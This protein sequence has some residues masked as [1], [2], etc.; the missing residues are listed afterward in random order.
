MLLLSR[1]PSYIGIEYRQKPHQVI[2]IVD[3]RAIEQKERL[4]GAAA[5]HVKP[6]FPFASARYARKQ[7]HRLDHVHR[8]GQRRHLLN[9]ARCQPD[10]AQRSHIL[11]LRRNFDRAQLNR[12]RPETHPDKRIGP[13]GQQGQCVRV[14][15]I[16]KAHYDCALRH[17][18]Q[19]AAIQI[20]RGTLAAR[21]IPDRGAGQRLAAFDIVDQ[22]GNSMLL[23][24]TQRGA[25]K[26]T[27]AEYQQGGAGGKADPMRP[28]AYSRP[29]HHWNSRKHRLTSLSVESESAH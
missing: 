19:E 27:G 18:K 7:L 2:H 28:P 1:F 10:I 24:L 15:Q 20:G 6:G 17:R 26:E 11:Q 22:A 3:R 4:V 14:S 21:R 23:R 8:T 13:N 9:L 16:G 25:R 5:P 29:S 12:D